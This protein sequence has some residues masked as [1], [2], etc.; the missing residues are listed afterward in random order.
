MEKN[1]WRLR[2]QDR[3]P[4]VTGFHEL[5]ARLA[6]AGISFPSSVTKQYG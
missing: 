6:V 3:H 4:D 5:P 2:T 1:L